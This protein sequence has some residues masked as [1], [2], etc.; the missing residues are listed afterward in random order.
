MAAAFLAA[1]ESRTS[2]V[3]QQ[4][5]TVKATALGQALRLALEE[6]ATDAAFDLWA[7]TRPSLSLK[8]SATTARIFRGLPRHELPGALMRLHQRACAMLGWPPMDAPEKG[9]AWAET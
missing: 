5:S 1:A 2:P 6:I 9:I 8:L 4:A 3:S 7:S